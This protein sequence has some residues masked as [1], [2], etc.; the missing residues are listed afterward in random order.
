MRVRRGGFFAIRTASTLYG[1]LTMIASRRRHRHG[2]GKLGY[3]T[4]VVRN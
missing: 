1:R 4:A 3:R 2:V